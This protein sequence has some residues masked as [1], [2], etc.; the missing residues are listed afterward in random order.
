MP[1]T[2]PAPSRFALRRGRMTVL[3]LALLT[4]TV[5]QDGGSQSCGTDGFTCAGPS[6]LFL[7][8][9]PGTH[10]SA[11]DGDS[12]LLRA[13]VAGVTTRCKSAN[14]DWSVTAGSGQVEVISRTIN[15]SDAILTV[16]GGEDITVHVSAECSDPSAGYGLDD[17]DVMIA[18]EPCVA[19]G[20]ACDG[21]DDLCC[22][23]FACDAATGACVAQDL[24]GD[25]DF[26][27]DVIATS[28]RCAS[29]G[30]EDDGTVVTRITIVQ[31]GCD[32]TASGWLGDP[33]LALTGR[34]RG[35]F[36]TFSGEY[37]EDGGTTTTRHVLNLDSPTEISGTEYWSWR[38]GSDVCSGSRSSVSAV[39][40]E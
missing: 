5:G 35:G 28:G 22:C 2:T 7:T 14:V 24:S 8:L 34:T 27:I 12:T 6:Q 33:N 4:L 25:W 39:R 26:S 40:V 15:S 36:I 23:G 13:T 37:S 20:G 32:I 30:E 19:D 1:S 16:Q 17:D 11:V 38:S 29:E 10:L 21:G 31:S 18:V 3:T 9:S